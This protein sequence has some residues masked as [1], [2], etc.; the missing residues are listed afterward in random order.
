MAEEIERKFL[1]RGDGWRDAPATAYRQGYLSTTAERTVRVRVAGE[2]AKLTVKGASRG[3]TRAEF[4]YEIPVEDAEA[5]LEGLCERPLIEKRRHRVP[6]GG[7]TWEVDEFFGENRGLVVA[8]VELERE[9]Q[10]F[11]KPPWVGSEVT[12]D[13][14]YF[15]ANLVRHPFRRWSG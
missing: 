2:T 6:Y 4:E 11:E 8:E 14:R 5:M 9:D 10:E 3:A 13:P 1:V 7:L 12:A 15:N